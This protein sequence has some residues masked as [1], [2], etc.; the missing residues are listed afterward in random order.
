MERLR[1]CWGVAQGS[2]LGP[3][4]SPPHINTIQ[5]EDTLF[6]LTSDCSEYQQDTHHQ[7]DN[8]GKIYAG[9]S[10][11]QAPSLGQGAIVGLRGH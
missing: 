10:G 7:A 3:L 8:Q 4:F 5:Q 1:K 11:Q 6:L 9:L 2:N